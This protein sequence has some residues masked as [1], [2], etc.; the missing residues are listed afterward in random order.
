MLQASVKALSSHC[1]QHVIQTDDGCRTADEGS[2][3]TLMP[4]SVS[5]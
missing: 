3:E 4:D 1:D 2:Y 5:V